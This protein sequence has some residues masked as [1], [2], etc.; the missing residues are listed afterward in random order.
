MEF[1]TMSK[2]E[3]QNRTNAGADKS[4]HA[5][6][7]KITVGAA[8]IRNTDGCNEILLLKRNADEAYYPNV[9]EIPGGKVDA[10]DTCIRDA[11]VR[12]VVE[13]TGLQVS[14]ITAALPPMRYTT[15]KTTRDAAGTEVVIER[16]ALQLSYIV[17]IDP[18]QGMNFIVNKNEHSMGRWVGLESLQGVD[19]TD[20]MRRIVLVALRTT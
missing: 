3:V 8:I 7:D 1:L 12:E 18:E 20:E 2:L 14:A 4:D 19:M 10:Q 13:E 5:S 9:F 17:S 15:R 11:I 16:Q 6:I